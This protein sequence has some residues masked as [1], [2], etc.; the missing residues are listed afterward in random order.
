MVTIVIKDGAVTPQGKRIN[1]E[2]GQ[3]VTLNVTSDVADEIHVHSTPEHEFKIKAGATNKKFTF[4]VKNPGQIAVES[5]HLD[6]TILQL[7]VRT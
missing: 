3:N 2:V 7:V 1:V 4:V 5:H 6:V